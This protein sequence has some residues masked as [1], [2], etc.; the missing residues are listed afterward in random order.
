MEFKFNCNKLLKPNATGF[1]VLDGKQGNPFE[2]NM[3]VSHGRS[4]GIGFI[5]SGAAAKVGEAD[6][7]NQIID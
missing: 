4:S 7:I 1:A 5:S 2:K 6:Q 3:P